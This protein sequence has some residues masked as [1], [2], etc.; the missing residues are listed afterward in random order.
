MGMGTTQE[1]F[2]PNLVHIGPVVSDV[3]IE[4]WK[5]NWQTTDAAWWQ[6]LNLTGEQK[7]TSEIFYGVR[8][9]IS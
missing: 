1:T 9:Y 6:K 8:F 2:L 7:K 5:A 3:N 4:M